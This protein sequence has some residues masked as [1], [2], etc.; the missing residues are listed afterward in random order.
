MQAK[1]QKVVGWRVGDRGAARVHLC[2][3]G[4][5][6]QDALVGSVPAGA[7]RVVCARLRLAQVPTEGAERALALEGLR[8]AVGQAGLRQGGGGCQAAAQGECYSYS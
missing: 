5:P 2:E 7:L 3:E 6:K 8:G 1:G 4:V